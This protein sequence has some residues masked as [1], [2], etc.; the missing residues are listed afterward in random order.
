MAHDPLSLQEAAHEA[1][2]RPALIAGATTFT[3]ADLAERASR[4]ATRLSHLERSGDAPIAFSAKAELERIALFWAL[5]DLGIPALPLHPRL[6]EPEQRRLA[7][8]TGAS[9]LDERWF[10]EESTAPASQPPSHQPIPPTRP[11]ALL[12]TSGT[13]AEPKCAILSR[14]AFLASAR[15]SAACLGWRDDDAW[16]MCMPLG[17]VGGLSILTRCLIARKPVVLLPRFDAAQVL[18]AIERGATLLS[19][20]PTTLAALLDADAGGLLSR[21][22]AVIVGGAACPEPLARRARGRGV[23]LLATYGLT[24]GCA[25]VTLQEPTRAS[26]SQGS[27]PTL[28]GLGVEIVDASGARLPSGERGRIQID[29]PNL[30]S[31]YLGEPPRTGPFDTGDIGWTDTAGALHVEGR[32]S[33][34]IVT[35][36]ENVSPAR[37]EAVL[38]ELPGVREAMAY[39]L[40][41]ERYGQIVA[42]MIVPE[43]GLFDETRFLVEAAAR[44]ASYERPRQVHTVETLPRTGA[45]KLDRRGAT[46]RNQALATATS[47]RHE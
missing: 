47:I 7:E 35:G 14:A 23:K 12:Y 26:E 46:N 16:L 29:G 45:G 5:A 1:P 33:E 38:A 22:R 11:L 19:V 6:P 24:E 40:P 10:E 27:G 8:R 17:H 2:S 37:V 30:F 20:V 32:R 21:P 41:D 18:D 15:A 9:W 44:L 3:F 4:Q 39:G 43:P 25:M 31:G 34:V 13:S 36:G 42:V 28:P